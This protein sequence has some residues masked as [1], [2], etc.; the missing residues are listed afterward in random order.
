MVKSKKGELVKKKSRPLTIESTGVFIERLP[1]GVQTILRQ[2][3]KLADDQGV[4]S[5]LVGGVVRDLL[6]G[7]PNLDLDIVVEGDGI[8]FAEIL[9][10]ILKAELVTHIQFGTATLSFRKGLKL[11]IATA[12]NESYPKPASLPLVTPGTLQDDLHRRDFTV[13]SLAI[14]LD[15]KR[16][17]RLID[18]HG[19]VSDLRR[20]WIR[21]L[22]P[23]S[24]MDDPTRIFRAVRFETRF[25]FEIEPFTLA[26]LKESLELDLIE[27][28]SPK[29]KRTDLF[30]LF[31][32]LDPTKPLLRLDEL[33]ALKH[34]HPKLRFSRSS[35]R[36]LNR[37]RLK[38]RGWSE[39][40]KLDFSF[41]HYLF[42][43]RKMDFKD[44][45]V[46]SRD[47]S[48]TKREMRNLMEIDL[49]KGRL[50]KLGRMNRSDPSISL[51]SYSPE[52]VLF[53]LESEENEMMRRK[54]EKLRNEQKKALLAISGR[55]LRALGI[56][57]GPVYKVILDG[58]MRSRLEGSLHTKKEELAYAKKIWKDSP[59]KPNPNKAKQASSSKKIS[60]SNL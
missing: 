7:V 48:F 11:D 32:E 2:I 30:L 16:F 38:K 36:S 18:L 5:Y 8:Q 50:V 40:Q 49:L 46:L 33:G 1:Q 37:F 29:R 14:H 55:D 34:L 52:I 51:K 24:F 15:G 53:L 4:H 58:I 44:R 19:G 25:G 6:L 17:G 45:I 47:L 31:K 57:E 27:K 13:N 60:N 35:A 26:R 39:F 21:I 59:G 12:R 10:R 22:H 56:P 42:L 41:L 54:I 9:S 20:K 23:K 3:G 28:L 43:T